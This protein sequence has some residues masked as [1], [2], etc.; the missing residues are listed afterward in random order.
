M[1]EIQNKSKIGLIIITKI[2]VRKP[3]GIII[4]PYEK[5]EAGNSPL[6]Y[7]SFFQVC[8][9]DDYI[10]QDRSAHKRAADGN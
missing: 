9:Y 10:E 2:Y 6:E 8:K 5:N 4:I 7:P 1:V 3:I